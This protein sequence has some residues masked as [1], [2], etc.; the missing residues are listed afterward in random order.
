MNTLWAH[1]VAWH[2]WLNRSDMPELARAVQSVSREM[3]PAEAVRYVRSHRPKGEERSREASGWWNKHR[4]VALYALLGREGTVAHVEQAMGLSPSVLYHLLT[5]WR[6]AFQAFTPPQ[7]VTCNGVSG[8]YVGKAVWDEGYYLLTPSGVRYRLRY[9]HYGAWV[10][11]DDY[12]PVVPLAVAASAA[13]H[14]GANPA[15]GRLL[16]LLEV[17]G[18]RMPYAPKPLPHPKI[19]GDFLIPQSLIEMAFGEEALQHGLSTAN[20]CGCVFFDVAEGLCGLNHRTLKGPKCPDYEGEN[21]TS[22]K[23][24]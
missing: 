19:D 24:I 20:P 16:K 13:E 1:W 15:R 12:G 5:D 7:N 17:I 18:K 22:T 11:I 21:D 8:L 4:A 2:E 14:S 6:I 10:V 9:A 23:G 3:M